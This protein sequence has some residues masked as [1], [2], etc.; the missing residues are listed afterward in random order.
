MHPA[1]KKVTED[2]EDQK[3]NT[4]IAT[5]MKCTNDLYDLRAKEGFADAAAWR[6]ALESLV[7]LIGPFAPHTAEELWH[8]LGH[9]DSVHVDHWPTW[10]DAYLASDTVRIAVQVNGKLRGVITVASGSDEAT[11]IA[12]ALADSKVSSY[13]TESPKKTIYVPNKLVSIV[14]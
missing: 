12:A 14:L 10:E 1:I 9:E 7:M 11:V 3:Y 5:M 6:Q 2:L 4:A 13:V 8:D